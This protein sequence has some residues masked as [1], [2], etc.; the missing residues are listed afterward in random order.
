MRQTRLHSKLDNAGI[1]IGKESDPMSTQE[2]IK[3]LSAETN[4]I[5]QAFT[6]V[7]G[8]LKPRKQTVRKQERPQVHPEISEL[9]RRQAAESLNIMTINLRR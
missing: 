1:R 6:A 2:D 4:F 8:L 9:E 7:A 3:R 5:V